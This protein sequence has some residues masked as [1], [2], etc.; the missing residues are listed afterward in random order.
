MKK[1]IILGGGVAGL[2]AAHELVERNY[3]VEIFE[4]NPDYVGGKARSINYRGDKNQYVNPLPGEHGFRFFPGFYKHIIDTMKRIPFQEDNSS[5]KSVFDNLTATKTIMLSRYNDSPIVVLSSFP[6]SFKQFREALKLIKKDKSRLSKEEKVF[7]VKRVWQL[8]SSC[9]DRKQNEYESLGWWQY[10]KAD[11]FSESYRHLLV[12]GLTRTLVAAKAKTAS[13]KTGGNIFL[14][15]LFSMLDPSVNTD[16]ILNG[17]TNEKWLN[18]WKKYLIEKGVKINQGWICS[19]IETDVKNYN[20]KNVTVAKLDEGTRKPLND[21]KTLEADYFVMAMPVERAAALISPD[22]I[23]CDKTLMGII[24]LAKSVNW[25]N[26][27]QFYLN[28]NITINQGHIIFSDSEYALT[29]I[30]QVQ[31]WENYDL[32]K[33]GNGKIKGLLSVDISD[34]FNAGKFNKLPADECTKDQIKDE[35]LKQL[36]YSLNINGQEILTENMVEDFYLDRDIKEKS[37]EEFISVFDNTKGQLTDREPLLV[38]NINTWNLRPEASCGIKNLFFASDY[39]KTNTDLATM[40]GANE[41]ARRTVNCILSSDNYPAKMCEIWEF[42]EPWFLSLTKKFDKKRFEQGLPWTI[43]APLW[44]LIIT[45][46][47]ALV[48]LILGIVKELI[49]PKR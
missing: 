47:G 31:F 32:T 14:Q 12:E 27:I 34:W 7:F 36:M 11:E 6:K 29:A 24:E 23:A 25:M 16:R 44:M 19:S 1:V 30:S 37:N 4:F 18:A 43:K 15:L 49:F 45:A 3:E 21:K 5:S 33:R 38:N 42:S 40:E 22:M 20:I 13:T 28:E 17:P 48:Y 39:V 26:G 35:V 10:L 2:S 46:I 8:M 41:A 9:Q